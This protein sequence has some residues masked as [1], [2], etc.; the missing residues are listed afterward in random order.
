LCAG[1][2]QQPAK[3]ETGNRPKEFAHAAFL[4][5]ED[6]VQK[7][8]QRAVYFLLQSSNGLGAPNITEM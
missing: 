2:R 1:R 5:D 4:P 8:I 3:P 6:A 7:Q